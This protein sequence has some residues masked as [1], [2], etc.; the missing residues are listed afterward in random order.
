MKNKI[1]KRFMQNLYTEYPQEVLNKSFLL[2]KV[3]ELI[4]F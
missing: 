2:S 3:V 4:S 1:R